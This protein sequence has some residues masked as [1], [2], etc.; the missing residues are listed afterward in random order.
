MEG[1]WEE[2]KRFIIALWK[3]QRL[4]HEHVKVATEWIFRVK[5]VR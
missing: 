1:E 4:F 2:E 3:L 5:I